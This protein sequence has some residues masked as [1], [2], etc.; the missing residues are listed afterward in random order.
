MDAKNCGSGFLIFV[1]ESPIRG[2]AKLN[3]NR[4]KTF[5]IGLIRL[6]FVLWVL[7]TLTNTK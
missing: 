2:V 5:D 1:Q 3:G 4:Y 6:K 7:G